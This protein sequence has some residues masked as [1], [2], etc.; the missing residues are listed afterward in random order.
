MTTAYI[1][2]GSNEGDRLL[3]LGRSRGRPVRA[4]GNPDRSRYRMRTSRSPPTSSSSRSS[5]TPWWRS[6]PISSRSSCSRT[7]SRS[8]TAWV[9]SAASRT[10]RA[11][12]TST[13]CSSVTRS[14]TT[15][16]LT[17]PHP[18]MLERDFVVTPLLE[19]APRS[20]FPTVHASRGRTPR[21]GR[22]SATSA[23]SPTSA[24]LHNDPVLAG[25][26]GRRRRCAAGTRT[27]S[28]D[29]TPQLSLQ[30]EVLGAGRDPV[31]VGTRTSRRRRPTRSVCR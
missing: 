18:R 2:L 11:P 16:D 4:S 20:I 23:R 14:W 29:G 8:R 27:W 31:R 1:G 19:I 10:A 5:P 26:V 9:G 21:W 25:R 3:N 13:S 28:P 22:S 12:S 7:S 17:I 6:R 15:A 30:R 24:C